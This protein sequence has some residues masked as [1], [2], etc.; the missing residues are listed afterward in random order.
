MKHIALLLALT[1]STAA[2]AQDVDP[3]VRETIKQ[4]EALLEKQPD[5]QPYTYLLA[6]Y[7]DKAKNTEGVVR[8]L[9]RLLALEWEHGLANDQFV[10]AKPDVEF[11]RTALSLHAREPKRNQAKTAFKIAGRRDLVPEGITY[12]P[13]EDVFYVSG[14]HRRNVLRVKRDGTATDFVK[15]AQDGMLGGL[16]LKIDPKKR[17]L[18][19]ISSTTPEMR[20]WKEG[21]NASMLAAYDLKTGKLV[22]KIEATPA[23][24]NDLTIL[25]DGTIF[26]TDMGRHNVV[27]LAPGADKLEV[28]ASEFVFPN[29]ITHLDGSLYVADFRGISKL[30]VTDAK[31]RTPIESKSLLNGIDGLA[32]H[33][34][35]LIGIQ[36]AIGRPRVVRVDPATGVTENLESRNARFELPTTGVVVGDEFWFIANPGLRSFNADRTIWPMEKLEDPVMLRLA[37]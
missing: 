5:N 27:R 21:E 31:K 11:R 37:L 32:V 3:R 24:L 34:G 29:G 25:D 2:L 12:D 1:L 6:T 16:G 13:V 7:Y 10:N 9:K 22:K 28:F 18:W 26:A 33:E 15:E 17:V 23:I 20:G 19:V 36:N 35:K 30:D 4:L 8:T 14:I